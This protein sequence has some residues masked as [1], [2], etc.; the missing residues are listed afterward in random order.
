MSAPCDKSNEIV[1]SRDRETMDCGKCAKPW[2]GGACGGREGMVLA[3]QQ[4]DHRASSNSWRVKSDS[5]L[6]CH[7]QRMCLQSF[8]T[9][10]RL[11]DWKA[12]SAREEGIKI[13][14]CFA[15]QGFVL[16]NPEAWNYFLCLPKIAICWSVYIFSNKKYILEKV[17][18]NLV[19]T[20]FLIHILHQLP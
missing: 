18:V 17:K 19:K 5:S 15:L 14:Y 13:L 8:G 1:H 9:F 12:K 16:C 20:L 7:Q 11:D 10:L 2:A 3:S 4:E 6:H